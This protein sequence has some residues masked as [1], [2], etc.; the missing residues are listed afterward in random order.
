MHNYCAAFFVSAVVLTACAD[1]PDIVVVSKDIE[2]ILK[3]IHQADS[4]EEKELRLANL[5]RQTDSVLLGVFNR[6]DLADAWVLRDLAWLRERPH[7]LQ[8]GIERSLGFGMEEQANRAALQGLDS[9]DKRLHRWLALGLAL[10]GM[11]EHPRVSDYFASECL[12][13]RS[14]EK[15]GIFWRVEWPRDSNSGE[16]RLKVA[17]VCPNGHADE[18]GLRVGDYFGVMYENGEALDSAIRSLDE[19]DRLSVD[20]ERDGQPKSFVLEKSTP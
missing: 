20:V 2:P 11:H 14:N 10:R 12:E 3:G 8:L 6:L 9:E 17:Y 7:V 1:E 18:S 16:R 4:D 15:W 13:L 19:N 5:R